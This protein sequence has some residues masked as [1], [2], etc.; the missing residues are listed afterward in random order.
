MHIGKGYKLAFGA[1][2]TLNMPSK[3][4]VVAAPEP[5]KEPVSP[6]MILQCM[7]LGHKSRNHVHGTI[8]NLVTP[9]MS[10]DFNFRMYW[11]HYTQRG[12]PREFCLRL[13][14]CWINRA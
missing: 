7:L 8:T 5:R 11:L 10:L 1:M 4:V 13:D 12:G 9:K 3:S 6:C 14:M 2:P